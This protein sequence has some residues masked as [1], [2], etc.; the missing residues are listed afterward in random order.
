MLA[1][2]QMLAVAAALSFSPAS[3][4]SP[5]LPLPQCESP[6]DDPTLADNAR[7]GWSVSLSGPR[8]LVGAPID[9]SS[10]QG[11]AV[12]FAKSGSDWVLED[13]LQ[14]LAPMAVE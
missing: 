4:P 13:R 5:P 3:P 11:S 14:P 9:G 10:R 2:P 1:L 6:V 8:L 7:F 12:V